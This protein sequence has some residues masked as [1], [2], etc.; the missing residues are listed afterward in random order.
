MIFMRDLVLPKSAQE[1]TLS[2]REYLSQKMISRLHGSGTN[3]IFQVF[4]ENKTLLR[5]Y[6]N[7]QDLPDLKTLKI[8]SKKTN[9]FNSR[10]YQHYLYQSLFKRLSKSSSRVNGWGSNQGFAFSERKYNSFLTQLIGP[11]QNRSQTLQTLEIGHSNMYLTNLDLSP[12]SGK[13]L[14]YS[15]HWGHSAKQRIKWRN[16]FNWFCWEIQWPQSSLTIL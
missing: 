11:C 14:H 9:N 1:I 16:L 12:S 5:F 15:D 3:Q 4:E 8:L 13:A 10:K 6:E 2:F 7:L